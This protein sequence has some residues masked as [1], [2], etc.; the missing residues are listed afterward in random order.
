MDRLQMFASGNV[1]ELE[2]L[3]VNKPYIILHVQKQESTFSECEIILK[4]QENY[5]RHIYIFYLCII[6]IDS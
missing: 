5:E 4:L 3:Q 1:V 6:V 2:R